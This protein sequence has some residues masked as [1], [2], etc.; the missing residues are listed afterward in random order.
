[1]AL[2][3][4]LKRERYSMGKKKEVISKT[5]EVLYNK[6]QELD[7][8]DSYGIVL[9]KTGMALKVNHYFQYILNCWSDYKI[10]KSTDNKIELGKMLKED[11]G[12]I[13]NG[14]LTIE[15]DAIMGMIA[16]YQ[17]ENNGEATGSADDYLNL[18]DYEIGGDS[19]PST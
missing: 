16:V 13:S 17:I 6:M 5:M 8:E 1:M 9:L 12:L 14:E 19:N 3:K 4:S 11:G 2:A 10:A 18:L 15:L 7:V